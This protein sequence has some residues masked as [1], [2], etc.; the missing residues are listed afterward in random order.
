MK[1]IYEKKPSNDTLTM[2]IIIFSMYRT[3]YQDTPWS[4]RKRSAG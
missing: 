1:E 3:Q 2:Q 4:R